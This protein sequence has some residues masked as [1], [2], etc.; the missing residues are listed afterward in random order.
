MPEPDQNNNNINGNNASSSGTK[1][2]D[3]IPK[4]IIED[5]GETKSWKERSTAIE[6]IETIL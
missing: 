2:V 3:I 6:S 4:S 5:L 1:F